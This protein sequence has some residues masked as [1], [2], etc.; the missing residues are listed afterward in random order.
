MQSCLN[1]KCNGAG[2]TLDSI[3]K[4]IG[5]ACATHR[6]EKGE[7]LKNHPE[8]KNKGGKGHKGHKRVKNT[9]GQSAPAAFAAPAPSPADI[10]ALRPPPSAPSG[11]PTSPAGPSPATTGPPSNGAP[12]PMQPMKR[13]VSGEQAADE[14]EVDEGY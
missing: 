6:K 8:C 3:K 7:W 5:D 11:P 10:T 9:E 13:E 1:D 4:Q 2:V 12:P 14:A